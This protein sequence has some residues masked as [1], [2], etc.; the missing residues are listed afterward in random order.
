LNE[1]E[2]LRDRIINLIEEEGCDVTK[3]DT[4]IREHGVDWIME[5]RLTIKPTHSEEVG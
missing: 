4:R 5:L 1:A 3:K 2:E